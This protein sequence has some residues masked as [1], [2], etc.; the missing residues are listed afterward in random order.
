MCSTRMTVSVRPWQSL[1]DLGDYAEAMRHY[2]AANRLRADVG[3]PGSRGAGRQVRQ[4]HCG[5]HSAEALAR[6]TAL[7]GRGRRVRETSC[8]CLSSA[9]PAP[10]RRWSSRSCPRIPRSP[11]AASC[12]S[13]PI[14]RGWDVSGIGSLEAGKLA[15]AAEDYRAELRRIGPEAAAGHRQAAEQFRGARADPAG[16]PGCAHHSLPPQPGRYLPVDLL[17]QFLGAARICLGS[18]RPRVLLPSVRA[19]DGALAARAAGGSF[20]R[21]SSTRRSSPTARRR[22]VGSS[23]SAD[24]TGTMPASRPSAT[25][26]R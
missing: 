14:G 13:G 3:A 4:H 26:G 22:R 1:D 25:R 9:C 10:A 5:L 17:H 24:W 6:R 19:A 16:P 23:P 21:G 11:P 20:H 15:K 12:L 18:R 2:E 7:A 8:R